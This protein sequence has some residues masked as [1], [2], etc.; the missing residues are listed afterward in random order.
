MMRRRSD[1]EYEA[2]PAGVQS[3]PR[4]LGPNADVNDENPLPPL[5]PI[6]RLNLG[7]QPGTIVCDRSK[8]SADSPVPHDY[9]ATGDVEYGSLAQGGSYE[10]LE[11]RKCGRRAYSMLAD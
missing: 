10:V 1:G 2:D 3:S 5:G 8:P 4:R 7:D 11:C 6:V 9:K